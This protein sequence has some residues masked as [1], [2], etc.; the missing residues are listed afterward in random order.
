MAAIPA[1]EERSTAALKSALTSKDFG[2]GF[3]AVRVIGERSD[4]ALLPEL[5]AFAAAPPRGTPR[6]FQGAISQII[7]E[8]EKS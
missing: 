5:K 8:L 7:E 3:A 6:F 4:V 2:F 1:G